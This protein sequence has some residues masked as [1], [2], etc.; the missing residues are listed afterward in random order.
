[1]IRLT[2]YTGDST[3]SHLGR[4]RSLLVTALAVLAVLVTF[5]FALG[6]VVGTAQWAAVGGR[7]PA[8]AAPGAAS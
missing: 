2:P 5:L 8:T 1:M 3:T 6:V 4:T 7:P